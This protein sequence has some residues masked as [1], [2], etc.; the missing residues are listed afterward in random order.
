MQPLDQ[1]CKGPSESLLSSDHLSQFKAVPLSVNRYHMTVCHMLDMPKSS[2]SFG[3]A[4]GVKDA[5]RSL[6]TCIRLH[7]MSAFERPQESSR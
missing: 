7:V 2:L 4:C 1:A 6:G 3:K 5:E